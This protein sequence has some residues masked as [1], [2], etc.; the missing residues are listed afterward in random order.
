MATSVPDTP[1]DTIWPDLPLAAWQDTYATL[2]LWTQIVGKIRLA[3]APNLNHWWHSTLYVT[4]RGL[5]TGAIPY[6]TRNFQIS[7]DFLE[8]QL[9]IDT[10]DGIT[11]RIALAPRSVADFYRD[12]MDALSEMGIK[13]P[14]WTMPQ[15][16]AEPIPFDRDDRHTAYDPEYAQ[17]CW[18]ILV[19]AD[20]VMSAFRSRFI[21]K[22]SPVHFFWGSFDLAVTRFS[23]RP[24]PEHPGGIPN[25][26]DW[27]TREAYSHEVSSC[28]FWPGGGSIVEPVFY[29]Y[30]YPAPEGF[31]DYTVQPKEAFYSSQ[32]QEFIL[33]YEAVRQADDP[34]ATLL[35]FF[36]STYEAAA[37]LGHWDRAALERPLALQS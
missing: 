25:M 27:V 21:G 2:H 24:A 30:A 13:V 35:A 18:R 5:T 11:K 28:G 1:L 8:H 34:D 14:I 9:Q 16:V 37:N 15:E 26:S 19:Q 29:A 3:L 22:S 31:P 36:Q 20:R 32:M 4:P 10:S 6:A 12:V 23:G 33:P 7:F 17:R